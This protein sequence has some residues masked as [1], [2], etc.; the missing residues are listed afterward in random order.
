MKGRVLHSMWI[1]EQG[2]GKQKKDI[3]RLIA[4][5]IWFSC[6]CISVVEYVELMEIDGYGVA[7]AIGRLRGSEL[8]L[9]TLL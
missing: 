7:R 8:F 2:P 3:S 9:S 5:V 1:E 6:G 4:Y